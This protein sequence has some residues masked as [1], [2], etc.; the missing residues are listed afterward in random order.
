MNTFFAY[1]PLNRKF[2]NMAREEAVSD[3]MKE[4]GAA[5]QTSSDDESDIDDTNSTVKSTM[6]TTDALNSLDEL[7]LFSQSQNDEHLSG[8]ISEAISKVESLKI[9]SYKQSKIFSFFKKT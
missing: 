8:L 4:K 2:T 9:G 6:T 3:F 7:L 1:K 5:T